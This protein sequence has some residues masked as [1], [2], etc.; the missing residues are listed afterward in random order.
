MHTPEYNPIL[1]NPY[2]TVVAECPPTPSR[3]NEYQSEDDLERSFI[4]QLVSQ[5]YE[6][7]NITDE[8]S[9][10]TNLRTQLNKLNAKEPK[11]RTGRQ[12][13]SEPSGNL[14]T[15]LSCLI[16]STQYSTKLD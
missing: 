8:Q 4:E 12:V 10:I 5:G 2:D 6:Y 7:I 11:A 16:H 3:A 13:L 15:H 9:L 14:Y 1:R